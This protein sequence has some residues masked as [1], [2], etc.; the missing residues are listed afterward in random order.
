MLDAL[1]GALSSRP[2]KEHSVRT[3][4]QELPEKQELETGEHYENL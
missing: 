4:P 3:S 1:G 2:E